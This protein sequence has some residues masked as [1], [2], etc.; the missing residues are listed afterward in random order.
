QARGNKPNLKTSFIKLLQR[1]QLL[2]HP[3]TPD[4][5]QKALLRIYNSPTQ[6]ELQTLCE[7][8]IEFDEQIM[9]W[10]FRHVQMVERMIGMKHGTG[11]SLGVPYLES[12]LKKKFFPELWEARTQMGVIS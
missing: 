11:G 10:R 6:D 12:T 3:F 1:K 2:P 4:D 5:L 7:F 8:L 9:L